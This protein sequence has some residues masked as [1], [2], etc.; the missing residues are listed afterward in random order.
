MA[1]APDDPYASLKR[2][3]IPDDF[4]SRAASAVKDINPRM[5][6]RESV[7]RVAPQDPLMKALGLTISTDP[8]TYYSGIGSTTWEPSAPIQEW[9]RQNAHETM[10]SNLD[11]KGKLA[12]DVGQGMQEGPFATAL[13]TLLKPLTIT[14]TGTRLLVENILRK[15][16]K[17]GGMGWDDAWE[18]IG[19]IYTFGELLADFDVWQEEENLKWA[20]M[21]G[22][23]G[24]V[25]L[26][27]LTWL[28]LVGKAI[29]FGA[30]LAAGQARVISGAAIRNA[31]VTHVGDDASRVFGGVLR[32][33]KLLDDDIL[34]AVADDLVKGTD[35]FVTRVSDDVVQLDLGKVAGV[36][37]PTNPLDSTLIMTL[38]N[39]LIDDIQKMY[40][41]GERAIRRGATAITDDEMRIAARHVA[42][43]QLDNALRSPTR[44]PT[45]AVDDLTG[46]KVRGYTKP[47][48]TLDEV[49][50]LTFAFGWRVPFTG[51]VGK[52]IFRHKLQQPI[53][54]KFWGSN[55][56]VPLI[57]TWVRGVP[58]A[59]R[60]VFFGRKIIGKVGRFKGPLAK[61]AAMTG[62]ATEERFGTG[63][64]GLIGWMK[65]GGRAPEVRQLMR[66]AMQKGDAASVHQ[67]KAFL[68]AA[69][70]GDMAARV[71]RQNLLRQVDA[72]FK[73]ADVAGANTAA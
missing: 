34:R 54:I 38:D 66:E 73:E 37:G 24:D 9:R 25:A 53:G 47:W 52:A 18:K 70:R 4:R 5:P 15:R 35:N 29:G 63:Y 46:G 72:F 2:D 6:P 11:W 12:Y 68:H 40:A 31:I 23:A 57:G 22:F 44:A 51:R 67:Y 26:D 16:P 36:T 60:T 42:E 21:V 28:G 58:Q 65:R 71:V 61:A 7:G 62:K 64:G 55:T 14:V 8:A 43:N 49:E 19:G 59:A 50:D 3:L 1:I 27:P 20:R 69:G 32:N 17:E 30:K 39:A 33:T 56:K 45:R 41:A 48:V 13:E 10:I